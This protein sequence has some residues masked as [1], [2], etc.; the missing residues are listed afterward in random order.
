MAKIF[1]EIK[2]KAAPRPRVTRRGTYNPRDYTDY[3]STIALVAKQK[4]TKKDTALAMQIDFFFKKPK[5]WSKKKKENPP[6]HTFKPD[7]DNLIKGVKDALNGIAY[8]DD[9]QVVSVHGRKQYADRDGIMIEV[10]EAYD[11]L[12]TAVFKR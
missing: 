2:P 4:F 12:K 5:S 8:R 6:Y 10:A 7:V 1:I 3:K 9:A 11:N